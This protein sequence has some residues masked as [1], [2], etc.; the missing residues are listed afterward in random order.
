MIE[1]FEDFCTWMYVVI[2]DLWQPIAP[3]VRRPGPPPRC[4]DS[5]LLT[6]AI[7]GE[8]RGWETETTVVRAWRDFPH[9]FPH[10]PDRSR[11]N[12]RRRQLR[13]ALNLL[14][15]LVLQVL[16]VAQERQC[17]L[18]SLPV[19][20]TRVHLAATASRDWAV[21]GAAKGAAAAGKQWT[22]GYKLHLLVTLGG[23]ILD[24][25]LVPANVGEAQAGA[26][27]L[28]SHTAL[29]VV[30]DK[31]YISAALAARLREERAIVLLTQRRQNQQAQ[32]APPLRRVLNQARQVV[33]TVNGQLTEQLHL[34]AHH[35][36]TFWGLASRLV[37]K[38]TAHTLSIYLNRLVGRP[39][40]LQIKA[41]AFPN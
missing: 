37:T 16:D 6:M 2:D 28:D 7:V 9:L 10:V 18:D 15:T 20:V 31:G 17:A 13:D 30:A 5:E 38:L 11:F 1:S 12:R 35:A 4:S 32:L 34:K 36:H 33:E 41:L 3:L 21:H 8:C 22:Y 25:L 27:L 24:F 14:R 39:D 26:D 23:V 29:T 40:W 19:P